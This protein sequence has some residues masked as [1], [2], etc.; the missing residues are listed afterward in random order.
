[1]TLRLGLGATLV[2]RGRQGGKLDGIGVYADNLHRHLE[3]SG[4]ADVLPVTFPRKPWEAQAQEK[5]GAAAAF[6]MAYGLSAAMS[7]TTGMS[8]PGSRAI[9]RRIDLFHAPDHLIP[10]MRTVPVVATICDALPVKRPDWINAGPANFR[11]RLFKIAGGWADHVI[12]ISAAMVPDLVQYFGLPESSITVVHLGIGKEWFERIPALARRAALDRYGLAEGYFLFVGTLQPRK[13]VATII[14]AYQALPE[15]IRRAR[16]LVIAGQAGWSSEAVVQSLR[17]AKGCRWLEYV[18]AQDLRALYQNA[19]SFVFPSLWEGFGMPV[20]EAFASRVPVITSNV[21][22]L[23]E[24]A[25]DAAVLVDPNSVGELR[26][27]MMR[28]VTDDS[29]A[30]ELR[31]RGAA[32]ARAM[33]WEE[34]ARRTLDV[35]R[36]V[37]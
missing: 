32:R 24:V 15:E 35:Y 5:E 6:S 33:S 3:S 8:F 12:A 17:S 22:S 20:L 11:S 36:K 1:M 14:A 16:Q 13:N 2:E 23:P 18:P 27:A 19:G 26:D 34:C 37:I 30:E 7:A 28:I 10:R 25:A 4:G 21:S 29:M 31:W 9:A